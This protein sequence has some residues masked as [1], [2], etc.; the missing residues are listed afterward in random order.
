[1]GQ[2]IPKRQISR[3]FDSSA[4]PSYD[5]L[6]QQLELGD[7]VSGLTIGASRG[8]FSKV[9]CPKCHNTRFARKS[10]TY[11]LFTKKYQTCKACNL[12]EQKAFFKVGRADSVIKQ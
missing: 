5:T 12:S 3:N 10:P 9:E 2:T 4:L 11:K 1:M 7:E 8:V 6:L